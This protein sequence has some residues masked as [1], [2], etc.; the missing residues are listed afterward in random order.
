MCGI[1]GFVSNHE[2]D[3][4]RSSLLNALN[5]T[6]DHRGPD[7]DGFYI[8][9]DVGMGMRRL[10]IID[11]ASGDQPIFNEDK[12]IAIV[13]NGEIYN[14]QELRGQLER[15][16]HIFSTNSDT[17]VIIHAYEQWG[18]EC[19]LKFNGMFAFSLWDDKQ[20]RLLIARDRMG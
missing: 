5:Q 12:S 7:S 11:I 14:F 1:C 4:D 18:D 20:K 2:L 9:G 19:L 3:Q 10:A 6:L 15:Y 13:Y 17:E 16:D 8:N